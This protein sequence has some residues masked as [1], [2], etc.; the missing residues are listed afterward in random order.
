MSSDRITRSDSLRYSLVAGIT[1]RWG[2]AEKTLVRYLF[3]VVE[4]RL[5]ARGKGGKPEDTD[6]QKKPVRANPFS[7]PIYETKLGIKQADVVQWM[8][9][10]SP[11]KNWT[12]T[13]MT[14]QILAVWVPSVHQIS[15]VSFNVTRSG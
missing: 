10:V 14:G 11:R 12:T 7:I 3:P 2:R 1:T 6:S 15:M 13:Q 8:V 5:S 4:E 9:D